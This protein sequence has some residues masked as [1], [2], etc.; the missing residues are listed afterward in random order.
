[1]AFDYDYDWERDFEREEFRQPSR[2]RCSDG[3]CGQ[4]DCGRCYPGANHYEE[5]KENVDQEG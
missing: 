4:L 5:E 3:F 2:F 1:M